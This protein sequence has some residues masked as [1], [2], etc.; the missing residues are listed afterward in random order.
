[1]VYEGGERTYMSCFSGEQTHVGTIIANLFIINATS[2]VV[3]F[4]LINVVQ[5]N[6]LTSRFPLLQKMH[7]FMYRLPT[8]FSIYEVIMNFQFSQ[9]K[10][11]VTFLVFPLTLQL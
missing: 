5:K 3:W 8:I 4:P 9:H 10:Y 7:F 2:E 1:M 11:N 6:N